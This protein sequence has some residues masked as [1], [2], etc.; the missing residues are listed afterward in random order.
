MPSILIMMLVEQLLSKQLNACLRTIVL[1]SIVSPFP[2][3]VR[4]KLAKLILFMIL[5]HLL[6]KKLQPFKRMNHKL[7]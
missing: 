5:R 3:V 4:R 6:K 7:N 1:N 2:I